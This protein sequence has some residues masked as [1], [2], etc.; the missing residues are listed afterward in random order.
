M[1]AKAHWITAI[2]PFSG[3]KICGSCEG[4]SLRAFS[5]A[6]T[7]SDRQP[8][9]SLDKKIV[10]PRTVEIRTTRP[11]QLITVSIW[12]QGKL[13]VDNPIEIWTPSGRI[14]TLGAGKTRTKTIRV[15]GRADKTTI[16]VNRFPDKAGLDTARATDMNATMPANVKRAGMK[17]SEYLSFP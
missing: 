2:P 6:T 5:M 8:K 9:F 17:T 3:K 15:S 4:G 10:V 1:E 12:F 11:A 16:L 7:I 14:A 13:V